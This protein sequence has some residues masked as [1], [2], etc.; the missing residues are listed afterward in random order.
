MDPRQCRRPTRKPV[1][2]PGAWARLNFTTSKFNRANHDSTMIAR[3]SRNARTPIYG[4]I[5][6]PLIA[7]KNSSIA[8]IFSHPSGGAERAPEIGDS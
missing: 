6:P 1:S 5:A 8:P 4:E 7:A 2:W 3:S